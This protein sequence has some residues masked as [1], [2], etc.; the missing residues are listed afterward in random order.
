MQTGKILWD[1]F[2]E[3]LQAVVPI[4]VIILILHFTIV[5]LPL[6]TL[7]LMLVGM[8]MLIV[9]LSLFSI[10]TDLAMMPMGQHIGSALIRSKNLPVVVI[11]LL[12]FGFAVTVAEPDLSV[13]ANQVASIPNN[14]LIIG[15]AV[16]VGVFLVLATLRILFRW[17]LNRLLVVLYIIAFI[18]AF[19]SKDYI[20]VAFDASAVT[21]GPIT[22]PFLLAIG[23]GFS[24]SMA[25]KDTDED[26]FGICGICSI[27]PIIA[28]LILGMFFDSSNNSYIT[29]PD[30]NVGGAAELFAIFGDGIVHTFL[31]VILV[32][33]PIVAIFIIFQMVRLRLS[34]TELIKIVVG[35]IYLLFG[36]TIF[37]AG[38]NYG[39]MPAAKFL[40]ENMGALDFNWVLIPICLV[41]GACV[42]LAEPAVHVMTKQVEE[43]TSGAISRGMM[44][45]GMAL[46]VGIAMSLAMVRLLF[47]I[48]ILWI[49]L[50][51]YAL[52]L[53]LSFFV[54]KIFVGIGF[55][56]GG[57]AAGAM[58]AAFVL[59]FTIG[60]CTALGGNV[61]LEA[62][63]VVGMI[64]MMPPI[65]IQIMGIIY[66]V[67][68][69]RTEKL[70][71]EAE[72]KLIEESEGP[73]DEYDPF[74]DTED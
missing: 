29:Q 54:P 50:P 17:R 24:A 23:A 35:L 72:E 2:K 62:F 56:S 27:G 3:S 74:I 57:V 4:G 6:G 28:V 33:L 55:D 13:L 42:V 37:L 58:S 66:K 8:V 73:Q 7:A 70:E 41:I 64:A 71:H 34:K 52:A 11:S 14:Q 39:F 47:G 16:G 65:T 69:K 46:G 51:G 30:A 26:T 38:V 53:V 12:V 59:P 32:L 68:L 10:G 18:F 21:T 48:S 63:G 49:L 44:L 20:A 67:K 25:G 5:P 15:I 60:V 9:G 45:F 31:E 36:L 19:I 22:V 1:K 40:G 61:I 43:V